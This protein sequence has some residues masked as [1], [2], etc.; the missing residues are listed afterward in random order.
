MKPSRRGIFA[1]RGCGVAAAILVAG[2]ITAS[3]EASAA[4]RAV[5]FA[6]ADGTQ[7]SATLY[8]SSNRPAPAI[9]FVHMLGRSKDDW[10]ALA[11]QLADA[12]VVVLSV[13]LR[14]H[15]RSSGT[16]A[17]LPPMLGDVRAALMWLGGRANVAAGGI[18][19]VG[20]SLGANLAALVAADSL[21]V[22]ALALLSPPLDYR[23]MRIDGST[24]KKVGA[25][26]LWLAASAQDPYALRT[27]KELI[28]D[29]G[30]REQHVSAAAAHGT[31]LL[32][33]DPELAR[34][35]VDWLKRTLIF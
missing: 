15:G 18:A 9:V 29:A 8:D 17:V 32:A 13:D 3:D 34:S 2:C 14:G 7:L 24:M 10:D 12:G 26:P 5:N 31:N 33:A 11:T 23:G 35:L 1:D 19:V 28:S 16:M 4:G 27:L 30:P 25:R 21:Q 6:A 22:R 20:A